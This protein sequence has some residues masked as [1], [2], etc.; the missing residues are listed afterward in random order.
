MQQVPQPP[1]YKQSTTDKVTWKRRQTL[2]CM[3]WAQEVHPAHQQPAHL[4]LASSL[5]LSWHKSRASP[6][7]CLCVCATITCSL[8]STPLA[9]WP[10]SEGQYVRCPFQRIQC[11]SIHKAAVCREEEEKKEKSFLSDSAPPISPSFPLIWRSRAG[12]TDSA[13]ILLQL[14]DPLSAALL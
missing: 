3:L 9:R 13:H 5:R 6:W 11:I 10:L 2:Y 8:S 1:G 12:Y 4:R 7:V 14:P